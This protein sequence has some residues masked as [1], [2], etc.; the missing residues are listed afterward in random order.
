[1]LIVPLVFRE[2]VVGFLSLGTQKPHRF[3][4]EE[5]QLAQSVASQVSGVL[6][7]LSLDEERRRLE[8]Q[9][10]QAQKMEALGQLTGGVAHDF[11]NM[12][13]V[14]IGHS[15]ILLSHFVPEQE[16]ITT[17]N[18]FLKWPSVQRL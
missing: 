9:Y 7:R 18:K 2:T 10:F 11:N 17:R 6:V 16:F 8:T 14:I 1:M 13:T 4:D 5:I 12:L 3:L 15:E